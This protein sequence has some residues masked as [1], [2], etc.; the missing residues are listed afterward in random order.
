MVTTIQIDEKLKGKLDKLK[1][2]R[3]E[4]YNELIFRLIENCSPDSTERESLIATI[5]V[6]SDPETMRDIA[7]GIEAFNRGEGISFEKLKKEL[8]E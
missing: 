1:I 2:H 3:R 6:L 5:E 8:I 4:T 7:D